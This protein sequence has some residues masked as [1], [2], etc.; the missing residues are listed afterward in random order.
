MALPSWFCWS[1]YGTEAGE[2]ISQILERKEYERRRNGGIFLWGI[3]NALGP[4]IPALL[5][6]TRSPQ[7]VFSPMKSSPRACDAAPERVVRWTSGE[8]VCGSPYEL[9]AHSLVTSRASA[10]AH[11]ALVCRSSRPIEF[12]RNP[13]LIAFGELRNLLSGSPLGA[14]QVTAVVERLEATSSGPVY[15]ATLVVDLHEPYFV[16][17]KNPIAAGGHQVLQAT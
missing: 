14:S 12:N 5:G 3:G 17:L 7:V 13:E 4:S 11:Y 9:P 10:R 8:S 2:P 15:P 1:K 16:R 6:R